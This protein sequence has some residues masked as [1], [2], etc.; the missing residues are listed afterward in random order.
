MSEF[1]PKLQ[2]SD[3]AQFEAEK[4]NLLHV[5]LCANEMLT[6]LG[7]G[8]QFVASIV[9]S[10]L[11]IAMFEL[12]GENSEEGAY[13]PRCMFDFGENRASPNLASGN[14]NAT[15]VLSSPGQREKNRVS[16]A[17]N[18]FSFIRGTSG[19][20]KSYSSDYATVINGKK[21]KT[22]CLS[23]RFREYLATA[24]RNS[25]ILPIS[26]N[27]RILELP[28]AMMFLVGLQFGQ[29]NVGTWNPFTLAAKQYLES[30][31]ASN[32]DYSHFFW[33]NGTEHENSYNS[34]ATFVPLLGNLEIRNSGNYHYYA[35]QFEIALHSYYAINMEILSR[36]QFDGNDRK[37]CTMREIFR[38]EGA[39]AIENLNIYGGR[40]QPDAKRSIIVSSYANMFVTSLDRPA[41]FPP[42]IKIIT[43]YENVHHARV[44][45]CH[46]F[47]VDVGDADRELL[48]CFK[49]KGYGNHTTY[50][51]GCPFFRDR[52]REFLIMPYQLGAE[53][54]GILPWAPDTS[55]C[56]VWS[57]RNMDWKKKFGGVEEIKIENL[58][59]DEMLLTATQM[60]SE[61]AGLVADANRTILDTISDCFSLA[62]N[63]LKV[64]KFQAYTILRDAS[65]KDIDKLL[66]EANIVQ[67]N[68]ENGDGRGGNGIATA[69]REAR[70]ILRQSS[71]ASNGND[72]DILKVN[73]LQK[74]IVPMTDGDIDDLVSFVF[75]KQVSF[76]EEERSEISSKFRAYRDEMRDENKDFTQKLLEAIPNSQKLLQVKFC[77][78][79]NIEIA[80]LVRHFPIKALSDVQVW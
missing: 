4:E 80:E 38:L 29:I 60:T 15:G 25:G 62:I 65:N 13:K 51:D 52:Q 32:M 75:S 16:T 79:S 44:F 10:R 17:G 18:N 66:I 33:P 64:L 3:S 20:N 71:D 19:K 78:M 31:L 6:V 24:T 76:R 45:G 21:V 42:P 22:P 43:R 14:Y 23:S 28:P 8:M 34:L 70:G 55:E 40:V 36:V 57:R 30:Q 56:Y 37:N 58:K 2:E 48:S 39:D 61:L 46:F 77:E 50:V 9:I 53:A 5:M 68:D 26:K 59:K 54:V 63:A 41:L 47:N 7:F 11:K 12:N 35:E 1:L 69:F 49:K 27:Q 67:A 72:R 73:A 74:C